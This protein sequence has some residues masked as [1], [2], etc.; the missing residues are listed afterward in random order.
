MV[1]L[2]IY[3][4]CKYSKGVNSN[5]LI[6]FMYSPAGWDNDKKIAILYENMHTMSPDD[7][8]TDVI[9][10]P[11]VARKVRPWPLPKLFFSF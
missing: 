7:Y 10:K 6:V 4:Y 8:Y 9:V 1:V 5:N 3:L 11:P 2:Y